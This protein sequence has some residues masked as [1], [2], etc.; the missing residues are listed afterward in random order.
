MLAHGEHTNRIGRMQIMLIKTWLSEAEDKFQGIVPTRQPKCIVA[1]ENNSLIAILVLQPINRRGSCWSITPP[2][3][4]NSPKLNSKYHIGYLLLKN[5]LKLDESIIQSWILSCKVNDSDQLA[6]SRELG[7]RPQKLLKE[8]KYNTIIDK[9]KDT[10]IFSKEIEWEPLSKDN[11]KLLLRLKKVSESVQL[12]EIL[13]LQSIDLLDKND[14]ENGILIFKNNNL[15]T[16]LLALS[17][18]LCSEDFNSLEIIRD[19]AWD[20]RLNR[21]TPI[22]LD[23]LLKTHPK[24]SLHT[25]SDD[26]NVNNILK[27]SN[28]IETNEIM[29]LGKCLLNRKLSN[30][31]IFK[32]SSF[33]SILNGLKPEQQSLPT[34]NIDI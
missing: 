1:T 2:E 8:W 14:P 19:V 27:D 20:N 16:P 10:N 34:P 5:A 13:D 31:K 24:I 23:K 9:N 22:L 6:I 32:E 7:F 30:S 11:V 26:I 15:K 28:W 25:R 17:T 21:E 12:R 18:S 33:E 4:I 3:F 29:L